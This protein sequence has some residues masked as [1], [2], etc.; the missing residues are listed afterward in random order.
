[1]LLKTDQNVACS[2]STIE[3]VSN[4]A[5]C[6]T[7]LSLFLFFFLS[8]LLCVYIL[9]ISGV[10]LSNLECDDTVLFFSLLV[11]L[12]V[13]KSTQLGVYC[14]PLSSDLFALWWPHSYWG[15][16]EIINWVWC[17]YVLFHCFSGTW[18]NA[19]GCCWRTS[20]LVF[21]CSFFFPSYFQHY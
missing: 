5:I 14:K 19:Y 3:I 21:F 12:I 6:C 13:Q 20:F 10:C 15:I 9:Y 4:T 8:F 11:L 2:F 16:L 17:T 7:W 18:H 1:M